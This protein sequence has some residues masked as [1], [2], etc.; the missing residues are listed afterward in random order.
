MRSNLRVFVGGVKT[1]EFTTY[2]DYQRAYGTW[3]TDYTSLGYGDRHGASGYLGVL[4]G[5]FAATRSLVVG[6]DGTGIVELGPTGT[7]HAATLVLANNAYTAAGVPAATLKFTFG[8]DGVGT[9]TATNLAIAAGSRLTVDV[10]CFDFS[11]SL[12]RHPILRAAEMEGAFDAANV[13]ILADTPTHRA[14]TR[15]ERVAGGL[16]VV[17][18]KGNAILIR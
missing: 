11:S 4:G 3:L 6:Q 16:D 1:N 9:V 15:V 12:R 14:Q 10:R 5:T 7:L 17:F 13:S 2:M 8:A 18:S